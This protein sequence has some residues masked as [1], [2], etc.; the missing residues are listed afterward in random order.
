MISD[1]ATEEG[2]RHICRVKI[3]CQQQL[4]C[5]FHGSAEACPQSLT[6]TLRPFPPSSSKFMGFLSSKP[7]RRR[8]GSGSIAISRGP[9]LGVFLPLDVHGIVG[10]FTRWL[11]HPSTVKRYFQGPTR[12][13]ALTG[14]P[15]IPLSPHHVQAPDNT[16]TPA[17]TESALSA[18][19]ADEGLN[20]QTGHRGSRFRRGFPELIFPHSGGG[21]RPLGLHQ[22]RFAF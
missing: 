18:L 6:Q 9:N 17:L 11:P 20:C 7:A 2:G 5:R 15:Q 1:S 8:R 22:S 12:Q 14:Q 10:P 16:C 3:C 19:Q 13:E 21:G 4:T